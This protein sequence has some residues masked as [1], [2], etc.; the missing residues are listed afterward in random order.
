M[1]FTRK[2]LQLGNHSGLIGP[3]GWQIKMVINWVVFGKGPWWVEAKP[4][5]NSFI[6]GRKPT[7]PSSKES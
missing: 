1:A 3:L 4:V 7:Y 5:S 6:D 2:P